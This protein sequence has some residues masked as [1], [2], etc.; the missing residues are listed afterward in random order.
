MGYVV[1][2][3]IRQ[4]SNKILPV[5]GIVAGGLTFIWVAKHW[6]AK[7]LFYLARKHIKEHKEHVDAEQKKGRC[8]FV[9][10]ELKVAN[11]VSQEILDTA[12]PFLKARWR[13]RHPYWTGTIGLIGLGGVVWGTEALLR[14]PQ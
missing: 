8:P 4:M 1:F 12:E 7:G 3:P 10:A 9:I 2:Y 14:R 6:Y 5:T 11:E 13:D